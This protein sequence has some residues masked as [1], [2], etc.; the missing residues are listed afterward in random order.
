M[1]NPLPAK[2]LLILSIC[3]GFFSISVPSGYAAIA[4][5]EKQE[6]SGS[7]SSVATSVALTNASGH[8]YLATMVV[9]PGS[10]SVTS[11]SGMGLSWTLLKS[12][13]GQQSKVAV[14]VYR[15]LGNGGSS[16]TV[17]ANFSSSTTNAVIAVT[18]YSGVDTSSPL[19]TPVSGAAQAYEAYVSLTTGQANS[20]AFA[21]VGVRMTYESSGVSDWLGHTSRAQ[22]D[23][24]SGSDE[25]TLIVADQL[26][27]STGTY[28]TGVVFG[29]A[30]NGET[31]YGAIA[32][33]IKAA[34][35]QLEQEGFRFRADDGSESGATWTTQ[36]TDITRL[37][38]TNTRLR[39]LVNATGDPTSQQFQIEYKKSSEGTWQKVDIEPGP[40]E[41]TELITTTGAG[42]WQAPDNVYEITVETWGGG[43]AGGG[44]TSSGRGGGGGGGAYSK[45][46]FSVTPGNSYNYS[47]AA[48]RT[49]TTG[50]GATGNSSW[51]MSN[52]SNGCVAVGGGGGLSAG[53]RGDGG[54]ASSGYGDLK[55][56]GGNGGTS[57]STYAGGGGGGAGS[58]GAGGNANVQTAGTGTSEYGGNGGAG[59]SS[60]ANGYAG[61]T[62]GGGGAGARRGSSGSYSGGAGAQGQIRITYT[63][64]P[65]T[66]PIILV[67]SGNIAAG[68]S[69]STTAQLTAPDGKSSGSDFQA[70]K[71]SDDTNPMPAVDLGSGKYTELEWC[72]IATDAAQED[73][74][75]EFRVTVNGTALDT[76]SVTPQWTIIVPPPTAISLVSFT[77]TGEGGLVQVDWQ[78]AQEVRNKGFNLYRAEGP[79]GMWV[80]LNAGLIPA[81]AWGTG[82]GASYRHTDRPPAVGRLYY[83]RLEDVDVSGAV[84]S[85]G[86]I[87]ID[88]DADGMADDWE[89]AHGLDPAVND[90]SLDRDGD[91]VPNGLEYLR[92]TN[93]LLWDSDGDGIGDG[94]EKKSPGYSGGSVALG[95]GETGVQV[96]SQDAA[97]LTLEVWTR[98]FDAS[99][100]AAGGL[101]FERL[102]VPGYVHGYTQEAGLPQV[103][104]KGILLDIP[105]GRRAT[106]EVL[107]EDTRL[108]PGY[109]VYPVPEYRLSEDG[110]LSEEFA[111]DEAVYEQNAYYPAAAAELSTEYVFRGGVKQRLVFYPLRFNPGTGELLY[112]ERI[113]VR[114]EFGEPAAAAATAQRT[115]AS[116]GDGA[117]GRFRPGRHTSSAPRRRGST[118]LPGRGFWQ[119]GS[120]PPTS[121]R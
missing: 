86:P 54:Q 15:A 75:Y 5:E 25:A 63:T 71:I 22:V 27:A 12:Q 30:P 119:R 116:A 35:A 57:D 19:G 37:T 114:V 77:V 117:A 44:R 31:K 28:N 121:M 66:P 112:S 47:V 83:Y 23:R 45:R 55:Y 61:V 82:E 11:V 33:E 115:A 79:G 85:H 93:P 68:G 14:A 10:I 29:D 13:A 64:T 84:T 34:P 103:P 87:C 32:V 40:E 36:D 46:T 88:W 18:R 48:Q 2:L 65:T 16:G 97:G 70:G 62:Y 17:T 113:R 105:S 4:F 60:S 102:R 108:L 72:L 101:V 76:Y 91:G 49:G 99:P 50:D 9:N 67:D 106:V 80:K 21:A 78:T 42:Q 104:V 6:G 98:G 92:G 107:G 89:I 120:T 59:R 7:G 3:L 73:D 58:T 56:N 90:A 41:Q 51:F 8:L 24:G 95:S 111:W 96:L 38:N 52:D 39:F 1:K 20:W 109:R 100:V 110:Q 69:T 26:R 53:T 43:G 118:G 81:A 74:I 94:A